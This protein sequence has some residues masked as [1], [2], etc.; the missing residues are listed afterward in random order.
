MGESVG[1]IG[2]TLSAPFVYKSVINNMRILSCLLLWC[3]AVVLHAQTFTSHLE[4]ENVGEGSVRLHQSSKITELVNARSNT[5]TPTARPAKT[6]TSKPTTTQ[7]QRSDTA[8]VYSSHDLVKVSG[9]R[10]QVY[11]GSGDG[12]GKREAE[13]MANMVRNQYPGENVYSSFVRSRWVCQVG[14]YRTIAEAQAMKRS[15]MGVKS[16]REATI[17]KCT[18]VVPRK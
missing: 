11:A 12:N 5:T 8:R 16:F 15:M 10:V 4:S 2:A 6:T 14:N 1:Y 3:C 13:R 17:V 9:Y 18:V 7:T